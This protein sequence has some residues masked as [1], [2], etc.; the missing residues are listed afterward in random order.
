MSTKSVRVIR[1]LLAAAVLAVLVFVLAARPGGDRDPQISTT[2]PI[3]QNLR[4]FITSNGK[5]EPLEPHVI[6]AQLTTF[7]EKVLAKEG[8]TVRRGQL[9]MTLDAA[10]SRSELAHLKEQLIA[11]EDERRLAAGG[12]SPDERAQFD[13]DLVKTNSEIAR[14]RRESGVLQRLYAKQAA[15]RDEIDQNRIA[16]ERAEADKQLVEQKQNAIAQRSKTQGERA[17]LRTDEARNSIRALEDKLNSVQVVAPVS[18]ALY[19]LPARAATLVHTGDVLAEVA[20]LTRIQVRVFV[21][22]P[23]LGSL[24]EGQTVEI[25]WD[26]LPHRIW[27]GRVEQLPKTIV[28]RGSRNV[29]EVLCSV[30][31]DKGELL[32]NTNV[33]TRIQTAQHD[34]ALTIPRSAIR[35]EGDRR[36]VFVVDT[37][38][39]RKQAVTVG[40]GNAKDYEILGGLAENDVIALPGATELHENQSVRT[41]GQK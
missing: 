17:V 1:S 34:N 2:R 19:A 13:A 25:T 39:L 28:A 26:A 5:V 36:Y 21:D 31:N 38:R 3:R 7:V 23:E 12:G 22:E 29:G 11:A 33:N 37:G 32:P 6:Q 9:L 41:G 27:V 20:D 8:Q 30:Q 14:L 35:T 40:I 15:T 18:G 24:R 4:S 16:L 10:E